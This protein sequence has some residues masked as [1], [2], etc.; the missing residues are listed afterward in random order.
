MIRRLSLALLVVALGVATGTGAAAWYF[1]AWLQRPVA[2]KAPVVVVIPPGASFRQVSERLAWYG[3]IDHP[4]LLQAWARY[5]AADRAVRSGEFLF[6]RPLPPGEVLEKIRG[7]E[8]FAR[9][10]TIPEGLTARQ[11]REALEQA[12]LGGSDVYECAMNT[13][14]VLAEFGLPAT[15]VE[16][17]L[18]PDTYDF[19]L[20]A[21]PDAVV[22][23]MIERFRQVSGE[24][25]RQREALGMS[26]REMVILASIIEKETGAGGERERVAGVFHNRMSSG[27][28]LQSDPTI[29]YGRDGDWS[30]PITKSELVDPHP[31][32]TYAHAGLP[33]G[34]IANPGRAALAA[35]VSPEATRALY[36]VSRNDGT[37]EFSETLGEHNDAVRRHRR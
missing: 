16:G 33:P 24:L 10:V 8:R 4:L 36:F 28:K 5:T 31:Y 19:E 23:R 9:R 18:F 27:M 34:P 14:S 21:A 11:V 29:L 6:D 7:S 22:R 13:P 20:G 32:N 37:H 35:A 25:A 1:W 12:G 2:A 3:V 30:R 26:E 15:G 17:Y